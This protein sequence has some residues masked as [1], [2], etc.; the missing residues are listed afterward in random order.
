[1]SDNP[2]TKS[3]KK[4]IWTKPRLD[5]LTNLSDAEAHKTF[6]N[7]SEFIVGTPGDQFHVG[8]AS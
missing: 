3:S 1:M 2:E 5:Y 7:F 8:P 4:T 6:S